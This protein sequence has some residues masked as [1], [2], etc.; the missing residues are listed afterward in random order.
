MQTDYNQQ[1]RKHRDE[2][3]KW[4]LQRCSSKTPEGLKD[5]GNDDGLDS[6]ENVRYCRELAKTD[7]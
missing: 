6:I 4:C 5:D 2:A 3:K 1:E 7:V